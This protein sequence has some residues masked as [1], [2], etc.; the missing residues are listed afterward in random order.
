M[1]E[2]TRLKYQAAA[3]GQPPDA[4]RARDDGDVEEGE[5]QIFALALGL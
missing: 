5:G 1:N 3:I 2:V 4:S